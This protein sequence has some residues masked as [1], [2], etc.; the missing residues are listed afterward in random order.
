MTY[1]GNKGQFVCP[2]CGGLDFYKSE[3]T[4]GAYAMTLNTPGPIDPTIINPITNQ[5]NRCRNCDEKV[6]WVDSPEYAAHKL[7]RESE[8]TSII[9]IIFG[10]IFLFFGLWVLGEG[11]QGTENLTLGLFVVS[12]LFFLFGTARYWR[13]SK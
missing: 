2:N 10:V 8:A 6:Y 11:I 5:V 1:T 7:S 3:E 12:A 4:T 9:S 13:K